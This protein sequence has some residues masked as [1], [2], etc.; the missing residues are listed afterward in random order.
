MSRKRRRRKRRSRRRAGLLVVSV[1]LAAVGGL[2]FRYV[3][4][5]L[6]PE[7]ALAQTS[8]VCAADVDRCGPGSAIARFT[9]GEDR[10][11]IAWEELP[12]I[13]VAAV[14]AAE[15]RSFFSHDGIDPGAIVR[16]AVHDVRDREL[17]EGGS[18]ITQ[19]YVKNVH[20]TSDRTWSRKLDEAVL[21]VKLEREL[22]K[23]EILTR[24]LNTVYFGRGTYGVEAAA[25]AYFGHSVAELDLSEAALLG[26]LIRSPE[27]TDPAMNPEN[28]ARRRL[29][30]LDGMVEVGSID[31]AAADEAAAT[32]L[33]APNIVPRKRRDDRGVILD[34]SVD[35][36]HFVEAVREEVVGRFG[37]AAFTDGLRVRTTLDPTLQAAAVNA[38]SSGGPED[39]EVAIVVLGDDGAVLALVGGRDF[40]QSQVDLARGSDGG[41]SGRQAG[42]LFKPILLAVALERGH[43]PGEEWPA[44]ASLDLGDWTVTNSDGEDHGDLSLVD[45][46]AQ[47]A[48]TAY[49]ALGVEIGPEAI[50]GLASRLGIGSELPVVPSLALGTAEVSPLEMAVAYHTLATGDRVQARLV[51]EVVSADG[52]SLWAATLERDTVLEPEVVDG[53][54]EAM[55]AV[56]EHGTGSAAAGV[57]GAIGKTGTT[58]DRRDAW[59]AGSACGVTAVVW[60][61]HPDQ[62]PMVDV[63][64]SGLP[65]R[66]WSEVVGTRC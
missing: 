12:E 39:P 16:A 11:V 58:Q 49:A 54:A 32:S 10:T 41:G 2:A 22:P 4:T 7:E 59:F 60:V 1:V 37:G 34:P 53:L 38:S 27:T 33:E 46:L 63:S 26:A 45:A 31:R 28:A 14:V 51:T 15:D 42:S 61:G 36:P 50:V 21:A 6:P 3:S 18:T 8:F 25:H 5:P 44:P 52:A 57:P 19:Q 24:Y 55:R 40:G 66:I 13:L 30:V 48:N 17:G 23:E 47:S 35:A 20:L 65:T 29:S 43:T 56:V 62:T 9:A 64:G